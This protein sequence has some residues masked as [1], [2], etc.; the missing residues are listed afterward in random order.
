MHAVHDAIRPLLASTPAAP[1]SDLATALARQMVWSRETF[2]PAPRTKGTVAHIKKEL[3]EIEADPTDLVEWIDVLILAL[4]GYWR[5]GGKPQDLPRMLKEKQLRN[6]RRRWPDWRK[7][8]EDQ[9]IEH[10]RD[11]EGDALAAA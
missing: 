5:H 7:V 6:S 10:T 4:D 11:G 2:G 3:K 9:A 1:N 8:A